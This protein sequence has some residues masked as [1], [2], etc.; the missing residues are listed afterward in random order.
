MELSYELDYAI[1]PAH[2]YYPHFMEI[3]ALC[4]YYLHFVNISVSHGYYPHFVEIS[5][6]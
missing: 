5:T 3:S 4:G 1:F 2:G 6:F